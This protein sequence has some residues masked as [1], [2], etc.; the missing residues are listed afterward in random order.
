MTE[1][2][3]TKIN[4]YAKRVK[5]GETL[6]SEELKERDALRAEFL[7]EFRANLRGQ[8]ENIDL[9]NADGSVTNLGDLHREKY[10]K[11]EYETP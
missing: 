1:E 7:A 3:L 2:K 9:K 4:N 10:G 6:T 11:G 5:A 8:L